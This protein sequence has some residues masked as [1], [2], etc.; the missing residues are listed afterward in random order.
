MR[1]LCLLVTSIAVVLTFFVSVSFAASEMINSQTVSPQTGSPK[2]KTSKPR[3]ENPH[4]KGMGCPCHGNGWGSSCQTLGPVGWP[5]F[6][7]RPDG[8]PNMAGAKSRDPGG[9]T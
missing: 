5:N 7:G 3:A 8:P 1:K 4:C 6:F 9:G 2:S